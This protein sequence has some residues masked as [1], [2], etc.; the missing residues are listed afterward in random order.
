[1]ILDSEKLEIAFT[2]HTELEKNQ[3]IS[4]DFFENKLILGDKSTTRSFVYHNKKWSENMNSSQIWLD[5]IQ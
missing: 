2:I 1:M 3:Q 4:F 5:I